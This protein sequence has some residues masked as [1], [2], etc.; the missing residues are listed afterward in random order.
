MPYPIEYHRCT[1]PSGGPKYGTRQ[2]MEYTISNYTDATDLGIYNPR[3]IR[4]GSSWSQHACGSAGDTGFPVVRPDGHLGGTALAR[5]L[6]RHHAD[7]GIQQ[8]IWAGRIWRNTRASAGWRKYSGESDHFNHVHWE[9]GEA[10]KIKVMNPKTGAAI[11]LTGT[12]TT[13]WQCNYCEFQDTC[14]QDHNER[15]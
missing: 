2:L 7:L 1:G 8:V 10:G 11:D 6:V 13:T 12:G 14:I 5:D 9:L 15:D 3:P 4:G